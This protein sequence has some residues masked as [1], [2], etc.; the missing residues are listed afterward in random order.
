MYTRA[1]TY[2]AHYIEFV[3]VHTLREGGEVGD[4]AHVG[5]DC[6]YHLGNMEKFQVPVVQL[7]W[8][9]VEF[10]CSCRPL[11]MTCTNTVSV[12]ITIYMENNFVR[13][14]SCPCLVNVTRELILRFIIP[15]ESR[16]CISCLDRN[17][18]C[19][20]LV[21]NRVPLSDDCL[22]LGLYT[23]TLNYPPLCLQIYFVMKIVNGNFR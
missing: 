11:Q 23:C 7:F 3:S 22:E 19:V 20:C 9:D 8:S 5:P 13:N 15:W 16:F 2:I 4:T 12:F 18:V 17:L 10:N 6:I 1:H 21:E 14:N